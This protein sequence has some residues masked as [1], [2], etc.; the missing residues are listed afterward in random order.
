[1]VGFMNTYRT[2]CKQP[3]VSSF[4]NHLR[5]RQIRV[6][7]LSLL[8]FLVPCAQAALQDDINKIITSQTPVTYS[9]HVVDGQTGRGIYSHNAGHALI[10]ASNMKIVTSAVALQ[11]LGPDYEFVTRVGLV[12]GTLAV[13]GG[14]DPLLG[15]PET[16]EGLQRE[17]DWLLCDIADRLFKQK[18]RR[19]EGILVDSTIFDDQRVHP[20]WPAREL[21]KAYAAEVCGINYNANRI[22]MVI[23]NESGRIQIAT[24]PSTAFL[25]LTNQVKAISRGNGAV[26]ALREIGKPNH[27]ILRGKVRRSQGV[28]LAIEKPAAYFGFLLAE[29]LRRR[30]IAIHGDLLETAIPKGASFHPVAEYRTPLK[31]VLWRCNKDSFNLAAEALLKTVAAYATK[32]RRLGSWNVGQRVVGTYLTSLGLPEDEFYFDDASGLSHRNRM[33]ARVLAQTLYAMYKGD[34]WEL[35]KESLAVGGVDGTLRKYRSFQQPPYQGNILGKTGYISGVKS[36]SGVCLVDGR[37]YFFSILANKAKGNTREAINR[38]AQAI[39]DNG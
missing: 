7:L 1:M 38:I 34:C 6:L 30:D 13:I 9:I 2:H 24:E 35:Y 10:P 16:E 8:G 15:D 3:G 36:F 26:A 29:E 18:I 37:S 33:S 32:G 17:P 11:Y 12:E 31:R 14:G 25:H 21:N 20:S 27:I 4:Y 22:D 23:S 19:V 28:E 5:Y 39:F